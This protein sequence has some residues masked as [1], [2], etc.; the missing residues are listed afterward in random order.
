MQVNRGSVVNNV[1]A[2]PSRLGTWPRTFRLVVLLV[3]TLRI[4]ASALLSLHPA[5]ECRG[6][7]WSPLGCL[8]P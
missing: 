7:D 6:G 5:S 1:G 3:P 4:P 2:M 8:F